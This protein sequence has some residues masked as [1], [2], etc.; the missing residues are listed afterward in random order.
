ML[1]NDREQIDLIQK[2]RFLERSSPENCDDI[3][4]IDQVEN[5][6]LLDFNPKI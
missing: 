2:G 3:V 5:A 4:F 1:L 6:L